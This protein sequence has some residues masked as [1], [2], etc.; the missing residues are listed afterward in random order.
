MVASSRWLRRM[1]L[2]VLIALPGCGART[3]KPAVESPVDKEKEAVC[4]DNLTLLGGATAAYRRLYD[5]ALPTR[6]SDLYHA[7]LVSDLSTFVCPASG[8]HITRAEQIDEQTDYAVATTLPAVRPAPIAWE[9]GGN[10][11]GQAMAFNSDRQF[12]M[13]AASAPNT[14]STVVERPAEERKA[15]NLSDPSM[16]E[17]G[18]PES[19]PPLSKEELARLVDQGKAFWSKGQWDEALAIYYSIIQRDPT[20]H[21]VH[22]NIGAAL[23][24]KDDWAGAEDAFRK[25]H[26]LDP[27]NFLYAGHLALAMRR[28]G[29]LTEAEEMI[30]K[31]IRLKPDH[32]DLHYHRAAIMMELKRWDD[33]EA[34]YR[35][36]IKLNAQNGVYWADLAAVLLSQERTEEARQAISRAKELGVKEH[37][38]FARVP[39]SSTPPTVGGGEPRPDG[40]PQV[41]GNPAD[42]A[43]DQSIAADPG[44]AQARE[45]HQKALKLFRDRNF[46][47]AEPLWRKAKELDPTNAAY[48]FYLGQI[49]GTRGKWEEAAAMWE[50][51][52]RIKPENASHLGHLGMAQRHLG[53]QEE[54]EANLIKALQLDPNDTG[55]LNQLGLLY[56]DQKKWSQAEQQFSRAAEL[57]PKNGVYHANLAGV[58]YEQG[59]VD[60]ARAAARRSWDLGFRN[61]TVFAKLGM[62]APQAAP[63]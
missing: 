38:V 61:H 36:A 41:T 18:L 53:K 3:P 40:P 24:G 51:A 63:E 54:A 21:S 59:K 17:R 5:G 35:Q 56:N 52:V 6:I 37:E 23:A 30:D 47:A 25:A 32:P 12:T 39:D 55:I 62:T 14:Q 2:V 7:G 16:L 43:P 22:N 33:A 42:P 11:H 45:L 50:Q 44:K 1:I 13:I 15:P 4:R 46:D 57:S 8:K 60:E 20:N 48:P 9:L 27:Q 49:L 10:H 29:R 31:A 26:E 28:Q 19:T 34:E 58:L